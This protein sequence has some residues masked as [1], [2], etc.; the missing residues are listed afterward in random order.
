MIEY[1]PW[2]HNSFR[3]TRGS[4]V[5]ELNFFH[6]LS[7]V[8]RRCSPKKET[9]MTVQP[10]QMDFSSYVSM[11]LYNVLN[12]TVRLDTKTHQDGLFMP[13]QKVC[14]IFT[15]RKRWLKP[16]YSIS[17]PLHHVH[18]REYTPKPIY[19][20]KISCTKSTRILL[21]SKTS[22]HHMGFD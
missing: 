14:R 8:W 5:C 17:S 6:W 9:K 19:T 21:Q 10:L 11:Q 12:W 2:H 7:P 16:P 20:K 15:M 1:F 18:L 13:I 22:L 3:D 4:I